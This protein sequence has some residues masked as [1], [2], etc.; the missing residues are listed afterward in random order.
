MNMS[1]YLQ[2]SKT[3]DVEILTALL[4]LEKQM[5]FLCGVIIDMANKVIDLEES[6][7]LQSLDSKEKES[8]VLLLEVQTRQ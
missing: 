7:K 6:S 2:P 1:L 3:F 4:R 8:K 5:R